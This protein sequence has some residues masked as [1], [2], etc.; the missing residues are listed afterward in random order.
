MT[1][2]ELIAVEDQDSKASTEA[3]NLELKTQGRNIATIVPPF[4]FLNAIIL[5][6]GIDTPH[7]PFYPQFQVVLHE[8]LV[9]A[10][11]RSFPLQEVTI[12]PRISY[13]EES[14]I[15]YSQDGLA[16]N[17]TYSSQHAADAEIS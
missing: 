7:L 5:K 17:R 9:T 16:S 14:P 13:H 4:L 11:R 15:T 10:I 1:F 3:N 2:P 8:L 12:L 6:K